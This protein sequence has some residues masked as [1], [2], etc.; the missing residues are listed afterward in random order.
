MNAR[1]SALRGPATLLRQ[2][3]ERWLRRRFG[4][5]GTR[6]TIE[7]RRLFILPTRLGYTFAGTLLLLLIGSLNYSA[8]LGFALTFLLA[9]C[10]TLGML[11]TYRNLE[12]AVFT[13]GP[14]A[15][16]FAGDTAR[17]PL[18]VEA[19][20]RSRWA[21]EVTAGD[22]TGTIDSVT[23]TQPHH[24]GV[25]MPTR[26]RGR[27]ALPRLTVTTR[28]PLLL[29]RVW[30]YLRPAVSTLVY[31]APLDH[32]YRR[33]WAADAGGGPSTP[34][35]EEE[36]AGLREY[37]PGDPPRRIAWKALAR[38]DELRVKAFEAMAA[39][40]TWLDWDS[41]EGLAPEARLEQLCF[42]VLAADRSGHPYGLMLPGS[43]IAPAQGP[44]HRRR[45]LEALALSG[46][47]DDDGA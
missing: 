27:L 1:S 39:D 2:W 44:E 26:R 34:D 3:A 41:L 46:Q 31:P 29:F 25:P 42:W 30:T 20:E 15:P 36:F 8:S 35:S 23:P 5:Q 45:C 17:F 11:H 16:V 33:P 7:R 22:W 10:G 9:G 12:G 37:R 28:W 32:G 18:E 19:P 47:P 6:I 38:T 13:F 21:I 43:R 24:G 14:A 4:N 40:D